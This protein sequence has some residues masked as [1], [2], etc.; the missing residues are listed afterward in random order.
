MIRANIAGKNFN[1]N[2]PPMTTL[3]ALITK[4]LALVRSCSVP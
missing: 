4:I 1:Q 2:P 3:K